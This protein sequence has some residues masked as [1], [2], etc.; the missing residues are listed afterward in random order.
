M[1]RAIAAKEGGV[2]E[3]AAPGLADGRAA[4]EAPRIVRR[5]AEEDLRDEVVGQ[6]QQRA[7]AQAFRRR[8]HGHGGLFYYDSFASLTF[9]YRVQ[10]PAYYWAT[11]PYFHHR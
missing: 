2:G 1:E 8:S 5:E 6:I 7:A 9:E 10:A 3:E 4:N 11:S